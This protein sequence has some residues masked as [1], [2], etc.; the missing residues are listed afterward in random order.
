MVVTHLATAGLYD[1]R[2]S[3]TFSL[4]MG[5]DRTLD[6]AAAEITIVTISVLFC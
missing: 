5:G 3:L 1:R 4:L 6:S 2:E